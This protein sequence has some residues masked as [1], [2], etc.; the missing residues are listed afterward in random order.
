MAVA[1]IFCNC[2]SEYRHINDYYTHV[3]TDV[4]ARTNIMLASCCKT[5]VS[6]NSSDGAGFWSGGD[7]WYK[8]RLQLSTLWLHILS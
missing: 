3:S 6:N 5:R 1:Q 7:T 8:S 4:N 2:F